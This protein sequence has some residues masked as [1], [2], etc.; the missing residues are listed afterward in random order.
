MLPRAG[1]APPA[2]A[3]SLP[4]QPFIASVKDHR[5]GEVAAMVGE[6]EV[7]HRDRELAAG[8]AAIASHAWRG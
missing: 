7:V 4:D 2:A 6:H 8:L 1:S 5:T 3:G